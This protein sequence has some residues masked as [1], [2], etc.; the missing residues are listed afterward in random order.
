M[1]KYIYALKKYGSRL[2]DFYEIHSSSTDSSMT[3]SC[4]DFYENSIKYLF[5]D[6]R[7]KMD[8]VST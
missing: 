8:M 7:L 2:D 3:Y 1:Y 5:A 6:T 4:V